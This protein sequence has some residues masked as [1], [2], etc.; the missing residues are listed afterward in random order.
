MAGFSTG[1]VRKLRT[2]LDFTCQPC[3]CR[4]T[5][6]SAWLKANV[7][8]LGRGECLVAD[9]GVAEL[10]DAHGSGPCSCNGSGGSNPLARTENPNPINDRVWIFYISF[11]FPPIYPERIEKCL[12]RSPFRSR[13]KLRPIDPNRRSSQAFCWRGFDNSLSISDI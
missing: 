9:A 7:G 8:L 4:Y 13:S 3:R 2:L 5:T 10:A 6:A 11:L 12:C 1:D